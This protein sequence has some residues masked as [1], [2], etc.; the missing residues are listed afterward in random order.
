MY[1]SQIRDP[2]LP[3]LSHVVQ[4]R[5]LARAGAFRAKACFVSPAS[6]GRQQRTRGIHFWSA[7]P[8]F[9][10]RQCRPSPVR[11]GG[12]KPKHARKRI[13]WTENFILRVCGCCG[14]LIALL[15]TS[16]RPKYFFSFFRPLYCRWGR[17][18]LPLWA[19]RTLTVWEVGAVID[20]IRSVC[21]RDIGD[22]S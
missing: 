19:K 3:R 8:A 14:G 12:A 17:I 10:C 2:T 6:S 16:A 20:P 22:G 11:G 21:V 18:R 5:I 1:F 9:Q 7:R 4:E 13:K 15:G